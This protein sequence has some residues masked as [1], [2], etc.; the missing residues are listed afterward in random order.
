[1]SER[2][3]K[4]L[5]FLG[6]VG[7]W[8]FSSVKQAEGISGTGVFALLL[9][10][11]V[12]V[13]LGA[14]LAL[15]AVF[16]AHVEVPPRSCLR[17]SACMVSCLLV[18]FC[19]WVLW[20]PEHLVLQAFRESSR[21]ENV[22]HPVQGGLHPSSRPARGFPAPF[23]KAV[24]PMEMGSSPVTH[25]HYHHGPTTPTAFRRSKRLTCGYSFFVSVLFSRR[26][27]SSL[28]SSLSSLEYFSLC[29]RYLLSFELARGASA[30]RVQMRLHS[31]QHNANVASRATKRCRQ[32]ESG[33]RG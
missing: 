4:P 29:S 32:V 17:H 12:V 14:E 28:S 33:G 1:M 3:K 30:R 16:G 27:F 23:F 10:G 19:V 13:V 20:S 6:T 22:Q 15:Q 9:R 31:W 21:D 26:P 7:T 24:W 5:T 8:Y 11:E 2:V 18:A 25:A